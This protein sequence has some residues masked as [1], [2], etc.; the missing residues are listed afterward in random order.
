[1][2]IGFIHSKDNAGQGLFWKMINLVREH[3]LKT[4]AS[5]AGSME[6]GMIYMLFFGLGT[7]PMMLLAASIGKFFQ[8]K[9]SFNLLKVYP[10]FLAVLGI[11]F[12]IRGLDLGIPLVSPSLLMGADA[13]ITDC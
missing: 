11:V 13:S 4:R 12:I 6:G 7:F 8:Q 2:G 1:M 10:Y 3:E 5:G 9:F